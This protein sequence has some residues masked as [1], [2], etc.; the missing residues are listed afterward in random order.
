MP[1]AMQLVSC[2]MGSAM[3]LP[4]CMALKLFVST[5]LAAQATTTQLPRS[6]AEVEAFYV[7]NGYL[8]PQY[9]QFYWFGYRKVMGWLL[10]AG[11]PQCSCSGHASGHCMP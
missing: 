8:L 7:S 9:H 10:V 5:W 1:I 11:T 6:Q 3:A 4:W 2:V